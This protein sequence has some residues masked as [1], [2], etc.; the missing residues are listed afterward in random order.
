MFIADVGANIEN[1][2]RVTEK[3]ALA[4]GASKR[5]DN[6]S[7]STSRPQS[8]REVCEMVPKTDDG[9]GEGWGVLG[10]GCRCWLAILSNIVTMDKSA[11]S[12]LT[13]ETKQQYRQWLPKG[14]P[15]PVKAKVHVTRTKRMVPWPSLII[16]SWSTQTTCPGGPQWMPSTSWWPWTSLWRS[17]GGR[18]QCWR[19]GTGRSIGTMPQCTP[20]PSWLTGWQP[21][22]LYWFNTRYIRQPGT[23]RLLP[24]S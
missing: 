17:S 2:L 16:R 6:P 9:E 3:F 20:S 22:R 14:Q 7:H 12:F 19:P 21:G 11:M 10:N 8:R 18:D 24:L 1:D 15:G 5:T 13:P 23:G 4:Y